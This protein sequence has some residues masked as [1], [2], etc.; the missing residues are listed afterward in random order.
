MRELATGEGSDTQ[1]Q[2]TCPGAPGMH[3]TTQMAL[4]RFGGLG[5]PDGPLPLSAL[6][7]PCGAR[8]WLVA[9]SSA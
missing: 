1:G 3:G 5:L 2:R 9:H 4:S 6:G 7:Q 8:A